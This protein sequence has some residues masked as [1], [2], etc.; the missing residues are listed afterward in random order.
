[1]QIIRNVGL[2]TLSANDGDKSPVSVDD[3]GRFI[4]TGAGGSGVAAA[5]RNDTAA[6][7]LAAAN[8]A[9]SKIAV[10]IKGRAFVNLLDGT[11]NAT[12]SS[13]GVPATS[14]RGLITRVLNFVRRS[15]KAETQQVATNSNLGYQACDQYG[16]TYVNPFCGPQEVQLLNSGAFSAAGANSFGGAFG[17]G[18]RWYITAISFVHDNSVAMRMSL[19]DGT[20]TIAYAAFPASAGNQHY[21]YSTPIRTAANGTFSCDLSNA[22]Q[23]FI[24]IY[25]WT[26]TI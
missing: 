6:T 8:N 10:D 22:G 18:V 9:D 13:T 11:G 16:R 15:D 24:V 17:A 12:A 1:M 25:G 26:S 7:D 23:C 21:Q 3:K 2:A 20:T 4:V 14:D 19:S 5:I